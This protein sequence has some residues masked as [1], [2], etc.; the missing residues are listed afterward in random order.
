MG[1]EEKREK[2]K[3]NAR[4]LFVKSERE[5]PWRTKK[6]KQQSILYFPSARLLARPRLQAHFLFH[7]ARDQGLDELCAQ[8]LPFLRTES[9]RSEKNERQEL[10]G[11]APF[12]FPLDAAAAA[13]RRKWTFVVGRRHALTPSKKTKKVR[14]ESSLLFALKNGGRL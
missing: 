6:K 3:K 11:G 5:A 7:L 1:E 9:E 8:G 13:R 10:G 14:N 12:F 2:K 4:T